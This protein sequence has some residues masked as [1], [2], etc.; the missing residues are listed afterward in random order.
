MTGFLRTLARRCPR[1][2][3]RRIFDGWFT[4]KD[5]CPTCALSFEREEGY[6]VGALIVNLAGAMAVWLVFFLGGMLITWPDVPWL[7]LTLGGMA[8]MAVFP[9]LFYPYSK[10]LWFWFDITFIHRL[11]A[12]DTGA[13]TV[14]QLEERD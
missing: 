6:W 3:E 5:R 11:E 8:V 12:S 2:G 1:C 7:P 14:E 10:T 9:V 4:L 13:P